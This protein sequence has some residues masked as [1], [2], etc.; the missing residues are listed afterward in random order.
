LLLAATDTTRGVLD[1]L[2]KRREIGPETSQIPRWGI[3][4]SSFYC[5]LRCFSREH[6]QRLDQR[7]TGMEFATEMI[8]R[9]QLTHAKIA[10]IPITLH[11]D[12]RRSHAPHLKTFRDEWRTLRFF[13]LY[14]PRWLFLM[15]GIGLL[16]FGLIGYALALPGITIAGLKRS[17]QRRSR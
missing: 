1:P 15:P 7:C 5:G 17:C 8:V 12:G 3:E 11:P 9:S 4:H 10:Q 13:L 14:S 2:V 6:Y 16:L